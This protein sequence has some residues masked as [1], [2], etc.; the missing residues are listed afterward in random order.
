MTILLKSANL[1]MMRF[2]Y[3][4]LLT[5]IIILDP[6]ICLSAPC[7][8]TKMPARGEFFS[9]IE[10]FHIERDL[11]KDQGKVKSAQHFLLI[12]YGLCDWFSID[13]KAGVGDINRYSAPCNNIDY[14][15]RFDGGYGFRVLFLTATIS[16]LPRGFSISAFT[17]LR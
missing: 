3:L 5:L 14:K 9:G 11:E 16:G 12:S 15:A 8:G 13:L 17:L 4:T 10:V 2:R 7:Y 6:S 1:M